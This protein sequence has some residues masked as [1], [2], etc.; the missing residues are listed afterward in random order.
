MENKDTLIDT[1]KKLI[2]SYSKNIPFGIGNIISAVDTKLPEKKS[3]P[4]EYGWDIIKQSVPYNTVDTAYQLG[5]TIQK[6][7]DN[8]SGKNIWADEDKDIREKML[9]ISNKDPKKA[10]KSLTI[11]LE[12]VNPI[13]QNPRM[14]ESMKYVRDNI[15]IN[16]EEIE[17]FKIDKNDNIYKILSDG[18]NAKDVYKKYHS[19]YKFNEN[20]AEEKIKY[21][22]LL[23]YARNILLEK[24]EDP[25]R[26]LEDNAFLKSLYWLSDVIS[27]PANLI[28][29]KLNEGYNK[30]S[31]NDIQTYTGN[32]Y[33]KGRGYS[34]LVQSIFSDAEIQKYPNIKNIINKQRD[35]IP[36]NEQELQEFKEF[37][38]KTGI[39]GFT[40]DVILDPLNF[41]DLLPKFTAKLVG[42]SS[43]IVRTFGNP[44]IANNLK[45]VQYIID[46]SRTRYLKD[47]LNNDGIKDITK[48]S[49]KYID[50]IFSDVKNI[51]NIPI[52]IKDAVKN[53]L[54]KNYDV[55]DN[56]TLKESINVLNKSKE[57]LKN[58][59]MDS[60]K[61]IER[62]LKNMNAI[63]K[64]I[65]G[66]DNINDIITIPEKMKK[67]I[68]NVS[69]TIGVRKLFVSDV[70]IEI[71]PIIAQ[72]DF[73]DDT[74]KLIKKGE[75]LKEFKG[76]PKD[77][78]DE[79]RRVIS[80]V[81]GEYKAKASALMKL[82]NAFV[83]N[84]NN[85]NKTSLN[86][87]NKKDMHNIL[88]LMIE[89]N[90]KSIKEIF[91]NTKYNNINIPV[92]MIDLTKKYGEIFDDMLID[93][94]KAI[95]SKI[96]PLLKNTND[97]KEYKKLA[98]TLMKIN[99]ENPYSPNI[100]KITDNIKNLIKNGDHNIMSVIEEDNI[101]NVLESVSYMTHIMTDETKKLLD[102]KGGNIFKNI[103]HKSI[104]DKSIKS[105]KFRNI[106]A[107]E[108]NAIF[109]DK[110]LATEYSNEIFR[111]ILKQK[112]ELIIK[113][114]GGLTKR[115]INNIIKSV[116]QQKKIFDDILKAIQEKGLDF[117]DTDISKI[118]P[119]RAERLA[120]QIQRTIFNKKLKQYGV[121]KIGDIPKG[122]KTTSLPELKGVYFH[123]D[124][125]ETIDNMNNMM[126]RNKNNI[127]GVIASINTLWK[128][129]TL[130]LV[131]ATITRNILGNILLSLTEIKPKNYT[132]YASSFK[133]AIDLITNM[134]KKYSAIDPKEIKIIDNA[135]RSY[136]PKSNNINILLNGEQ[137]IKEAGDII[138]TSFKEID[139]KKADEF[140]NI[141]EGVIGNVKSG[142]L[143]M[144]KKISG[145]PLA[146]INDNAEKISKL[147]LFIENIKQGKSIK[148]A[149]SSV[150][151]TLFDYG[152]LTS[153]E[154]K[155]RDTV[156]PFYT[157]MRKNIVFQFEHI[158]DVIPRFFM[159][160][161]NS[162]NQPGGIGDSLSKYDTETLSI[163]E[164]A[165]KYIKTQSKLEL[166]MSEPFNPD[167][168]L[169]NNIIPF[170]DINK[171]S[172][173]I[174]NLF[175]KD[176]NFA[177]K[178]FNGI[179]EE[180]LANTNPII[181]TTA[182]NI[183]NKK[184]DYNTPVSRGE[185]T[186]TEYLGMQISP[187][188]K[189]ILDDW[190]AFGI[191]NNVAIAYKQSKGEATLNP[192]E[193]QLKNILLSFF[194]ANSTKSDQVFNKTMSDIDVN[195]RIN[196]EVSSFRSYVNRYKD[197][198]KS[199]KTLNK[200]QAYSIID[201][202]SKTY[203][204]ILE[205]KEKNKISDE[206]Y[207][208]YTSS[209]V[210]IFK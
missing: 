22:K 124:I 56:N 75:L 95:G 41:V 146:E 18:N 172:K 207:K 6:S 34:E 65:A 145:L 45:K 176:G 80:T 78:F 181:K 67:I 157:F 60:Y 71:K 132:S 190:R 49:L 64:D 140:T 108:L 82:E 178:L 185:Y 84:I 48:S 173:F 68:D 46:G 201:T 52:N 210:N 159:K 74:G 16:P 137:I 81:S 131:P 116:E 99:S 69:E 2:K 103:M 36:L 168:M 105:R 202:A 70:P 1:G 93:E 119:I 51:D 206:Y 87:I 189:N 208:R 44:L 183:L 79:A 29:Y 4:L 53:T 7:I 129:S 66:V 139:I 47:I 91:S 193:K 184:I 150:Y 130:N 155:L 42:K 138:R 3:T 200:E 199:G 100:I 128:S 90:G 204:I 135:I 120:R 110:E 38:F 171:V 10:Y 98:D 166:G 8:W 20:S 89:K 76:S 106:S 23:S 92:N 50:D 182:E 209:I 5:Q 143:G 133:E 192:E 33:M 153:T 97:I 21:R 40:G 17:E 123:P 19:M 85:I 104:T 170:F 156:I 32:D 194:I 77:V 113:T 158:L 165:N 37:N 58:I 151:K 94:I 127:I 203:K 114:K 117:F 61:T 83:N 107:Y 59:N 86:K 161:E 109:K 164:E 26:I 169:L 13:T 28:A 177:Q 152:D 196:N 147:A 126:T 118:I 9:E 162:F 14:Y 160:M 154:R 35:N 125:V 163:P 62:Q 73:I 179:T 180:T 142:I 174:G 39:F 11:A 111:N 115:N 195:N 149:K 136:M 31:D 188:I 186:K 191:A 54:I 57:Y 72:N 148:Q 167:Y 63:S 30:L 55:W 27:V 25:E 198:I 187:Y 175:E 144:A 12:T 134:Y 101:D 43:D 121:N 24:G 88:S 102:I 197:Q 141:A 15:D 96:T 122:W 205:A 112:E